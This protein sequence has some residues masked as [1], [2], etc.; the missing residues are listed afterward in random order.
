MFTVS[1]RI[2][3]GNIHGAGVYVN[4]SASSRYPYPKDTPLF[5]SEKGGSKTYLTTVIESVATRRDPNTYNW[6]IR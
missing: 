4:G 5:V 1:F 3:I 6:E 2:P